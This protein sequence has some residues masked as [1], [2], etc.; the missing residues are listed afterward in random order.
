MAAKRR[1]FRASGANPFGSVA[2][3]STQFMEDIWDVLTGAHVE[4]FKRAPAVVDTS[5]H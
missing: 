3:N 2:L 1:S 4:P 5:H